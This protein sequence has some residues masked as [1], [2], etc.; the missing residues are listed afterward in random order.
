MIVAIIAILF[1]TGP[2]S[3]QILP[4]DPMQPPVVEPPQ[5]PTPTPT[6]R[7]PAG[8]L[9]DPPIVEPPQVSTADI[10]QPPA[11]T[12]TIE[13]T[14]VPTQPPAA[15]PT[16]EPTQVPTQ[17]P[18]ATPTPPATAPPQAPTLTPQN[19]S[20]GA[21]LQ[22]SGGPG[23][24]LFPVIS[25]NRIA[26]F[27]DESS[28]VQL[29]NLLTGNTTTISAE[30]PIPLML[31][32][33][34]DIS[35]DYVV[36]TEVSQ[37]TESYILLYEISS[38]TMQ[39]V[40]DGSGW[41]GL[42]GVSENYIVWIAGDERGDVYLYDIA[43]GNITQVTDDPYEQLWPD[44]GGTTV[45]WAD[46]E[47]EEGDL[48]IAVAA[49]GQPGV[50]LLGDSGDDSYPDVS[51]DGSHVAWISILDNRTVVYLYDVTTE[52]ITQVTGESAEPDAVTVDGD[53]VVY[54]DWRN[55]NLDL[56]VYDIRTGV[57]TPVIEDPYHQSYP[58]ISAGRIVWMGNNTGQWEIYTADVPAG[59]SPGPIGPAPVE[60][61]PAEPTPGQ[62]PPAGQTP[63][64]TFPVQ[65]PTAGPTPAQTSPPGSGNGLTITAAEIAALQ[66]QESPEL[67]GWLTA[68]DPARGLTFYTNPSSPDIVLIETASGTWYGYSISTGYL[69]QVEM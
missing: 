6:S 14:Q 17:P 52:N 34:L 27:D 30:T 63:A 56:Y 21:G 39:Q 60:T 32:Y 48:D 50:R 47:T 19:A 24:K 12:P 5:P 54:S 58:E 66:W 61:I 29:H 35:G 41:P 7:P 2:A 51:S 65:T 8:V 22:L 9:P 33:E 64:Q 3:A 38:G 4:V 49:P 42:P 31:P 68:E 36:W 53:H 18:A 69:T 26:W 43:S 57:E 44:V 1:V 10:T 20:A 37:P 45:A 46:N 28:S 67:P 40:T 62:T 23:D 59:P 25:R 11:V 55:G 13:P 15:T 16:I